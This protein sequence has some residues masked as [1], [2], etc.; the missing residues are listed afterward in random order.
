VKAIETAVAGKYSLRE[1]VVCKVAHGNNLEF[2]LLP[3]L[4]K[5]PEVAAARKKLDSANSAKQNK[6]EKL[7]K[8]YRNQLFNISNGKDF[9]AFEADS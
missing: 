3:N 9:D 2:E 8:W 7:K 1:K 4:D 6:R 5:I